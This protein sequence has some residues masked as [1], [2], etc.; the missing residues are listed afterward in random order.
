MPTLIEQI[1]HAANRATK[2]C[3]GCGCQFTNRRGVSPARWSRRQFHDCECYAEY[4]RGKT[5]PPCWTDAEIIILRETYQ[6][7][8]SPA[9]AQA[10]P[11]KTQDQVSSKAV[12]LGLVSGLQPGGHRTPRILES[13]EA[14]ASGQH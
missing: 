5:K 8:G 14:T 9:A 10:L 2:T 1:D 7:G 3:L 6:A 4:A 12:K 13:Q 11:D